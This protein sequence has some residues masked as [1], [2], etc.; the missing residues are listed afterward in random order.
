MQLPA[1]VCPSALR[2]N[3]RK[4]GYLSQQIPGPTPFLTELPA[5]PLWPLFTEPLCVPTTTLPGPLPSLGI[6]RDPYPSH[7]HTTSPPAPGRTVLG[8]LLSPPPPSLIQQRFTAPY[9]TRFN[10]WVGKIPWRRAWQPTPGVLPG[11]TP[12]TEEPGRLQSTGLQRVGPDWVT[13][14]ST[15]E[16]SLDFCTGTSNCSLNE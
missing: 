14:H 9:P 10:L 6:H 12:W 16:A 2:L 11:E 13:K 15:A 4:P 3:P 8:L 7:T 5:L 1:L